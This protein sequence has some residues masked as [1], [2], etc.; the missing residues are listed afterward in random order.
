MKNHQRRIRP[1]KIQWGRLSHMFFQV[2]KSRR[3][4]EY[5][6]ALWKKEERILI[7]IIW[8]SGKLLPRR[9]KELWWNYSKRSRMRRSLQTRVNTGQILC[10]K[11]SIDKGSSM[12]KKKLRRRKYWK[13]MLSSVSKYQTRKTS[14]NS[15]KYSKRNWRKKIRSLNSL[16]K[17]KS[18][19]T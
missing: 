2:K 3:L 10:C 1:S 13:P 7:S 14:N 8:L 18:E 11:E 19:R 5:L 17:H 9:T 12:R 6:G 4:Q 16:S 15:Q